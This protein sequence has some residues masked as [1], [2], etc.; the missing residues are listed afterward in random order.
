[1]SPLGIFGITAF[2]SSANES[3]IYNESIN[4]NDAI[5]PLN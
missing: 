2:L 1:M 4:V 5:A 3:L